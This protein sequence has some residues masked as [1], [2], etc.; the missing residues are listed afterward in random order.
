MAVYV[1]FFFRARAAHGYAAL[2]ITGLGLALLV[3]RA[4]A[5]GV[6]VWLTISAMVGLAVA[7]LAGLE[8]RA[9][10]PRRTPTTSPACSTAPGSP[11]P[12]RASARWP[13]AAVSCSRSR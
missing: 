7:I 11:R 12:P 4:P 10:A 2:M 1:A 13:D 6:S 9:C 3:A 5:S 8:T